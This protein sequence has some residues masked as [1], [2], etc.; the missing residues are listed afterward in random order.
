MSAKAMA[1]QAIRKLGPA[2]WSSPAIMRARCA[3][4]ARCSAPYG[5]ELVSAG[6]LDLP[7]PEET[8]TTFVANALIKARAAADLRACR[9]WPTTAAC[10]SRRWAATRRLHR[11]WAE[12]QWFEGDP[13]RDWYMAM[14]KVEGMLQATG[15]GRDRA[16]R[17]SSA[18]WRSPGPTAHVD[19]SKAASTAR[20]PGRRAATMGFGYDPM[21]V[22]DGR[23]ADLRRDGSR[24][25]A[26]I[27]HRADAFAKLVAEQFG[28]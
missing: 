3:K 6:E 26:R 16:M 5:I 24:G 19:G 8:G 12:R 21:F 25:K 17:S 4:S 20:W 15:P 10:A 13:G 23:D 1:P 18:R 27:S 2:S 9:R 7:E 14:G 11:R 22:P 28:G